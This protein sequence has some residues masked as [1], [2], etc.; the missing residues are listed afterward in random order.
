MKAEVSVTFEFDQRAPLTHRVEVEALK[1]RTVVWRAITA[2][3]KAVKPMKWRS[4]VVVVTRQAED[5]VQD[6]VEE[7]DV[8][9][10]FDAE[11]GLV[12]EVAG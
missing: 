8:P 7:A 2:A 9:L 6:G 4:M 12:V 1:P 11:M 10:P 5:A 3:Q